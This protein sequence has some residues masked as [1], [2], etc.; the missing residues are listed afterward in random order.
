MT[1]AVPA[2][3]MKD[4]TPTM[5]PETDRATNHSL[6]PAAGR[7]RAVTPSLLDAATDTVAYLSIAVIAVELLIG[8]YALAS[9]AV[10]AA[11]LLAVTLIGAAAGLVSALLVYPQRRGQ[12]PAR[13][14]WLLAL[15]GAFVLAAREGVE[16]GVA[17]GQLAAVPVAAVSHTWMV[18][19][20]I[21]AALFAAKLVIHKR[22][23]DRLS[24]SQS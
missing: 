19:A 16:H 17:T 14:I 20:A 8:S 7:T 9:A 12:K 5:N 22:R 10:P 4:M 23:G 2:A 15:A 18:L 11:T 1:R 13:H 6:P 21:W 24:A 3:H